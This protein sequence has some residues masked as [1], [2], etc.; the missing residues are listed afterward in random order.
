MVLVFECPVDNCCYIY[1]NVFT[2]FE[3]VCLEGFVQN[4]HCNL[5]FPA[6]K[7]YKVLKSSNDLE[8][9]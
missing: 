9:L 4:E 2:S 6:E 5:M 7:K 8:E 1:S 3:Y